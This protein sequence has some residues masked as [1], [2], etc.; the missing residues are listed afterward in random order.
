MDDLNRL[1]NR[2]I[3]FT[4]DIG[5]GVGNAPASVLEGVS[6][7]EKGLQMGGSATLSL[8]ETSKDFPQLSVK[9]GATKLG[10]A[11][12]TLMETSKDFSLSSVKTSLQGGGN[13]TLSLME[14][15]SYNGDCSERG[16]ASLYA[17]TDADLSKHPTTSTREPAITALVGSGILFPVSE[18]RYVDVK[19]VHRFIRVT[20]PSFTVIEVGDV[21]D[22]IMCLE[23]GV[24]TVFSS[25]ASADLRAALLSVSGQA[26]L[27][28]HLSIPV[29]VKGL[30]YMMSSLDNVRFDATLRFWAKLKEVERHIQKYLE[31]EAVGQVLMR[32]A[33]EWENSYYIGS[34]DV[35]FYT[36]VE[37]TH[38]PPPIF[39]VERDLNAVCDLETY[40][41]KSIRD[42]VEVSTYTDQI[43]NVWNYSRNF[44]REAFIVHP[45]G[46][47]FARDSIMYR[48]QRIMILLTTILSILFSEVLFAESAIAGER[49]EH[50]VAEDSLLEQVLEKIVFGA[51]G[52]VVASLVRVVI[53]FVFE[54]AMSAQHRVEQYDD[55]AKRSKT[56]PGD[57]SIDMPI[58]VI[59]HEVFLSRAKLRLGKSHYQVYTE[60]EHLHDREPLSEE[61]LLGILKYHV[62]KTERVYREAMK[63]QKVADAAHVAAQMQHSKARGLKYFWQRRTLQKQRAAEHY[64]KHLEFHLQ[65]HSTF[66]KERFLRSKATKEEMG[67]I[68]GTLYWLLLVHPSEKINPP[69]MTNGVHRPAVA[70]AQ[71]AGAWMVSALWNA[72]CFLYI[73]LWLFKT[74]S[75]T[76]WVLNSSTAFAMTWCFSSPVGIFVKA[77]VLPILT[78]LCCGMNRSEG[79]SPPPPKQGGGGQK[80]ESAMRTSELTSAFQDER[81]V[82]DNG[83][84]GAMSGRSSFLMK[85]AGLQH[86]TEFVFEDLEHFSLENSV[87]RPDVEAV[88]KRR[89][90]QQRAEVESRTREAQRIMMLT[91]PMTMTIIH[92]N[93]DHSD[94]RIED[95]ELQLSENGVP[96]TE[97]DYVDEQLTA[98]K[99]DGDDNGD[100]VSWYDSLRESFSGLF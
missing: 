32:Q 40:E 99:N 47:I 88:L 22:Q 52:A 61:L 65:R 59:R 95:V 97:E 37:A 49:D 35:Q 73:I 51:L 57:L 75:A 8:M 53:K 83:G 46:M 26:S 94:T 13:A 17:L 34:K 2:A 69:P 93:N 71:I 63:L 27:F 14:R 4:E 74:Q 82:L 92:D 87:S 79:G 48:H 78:V 62:T 41:I 70:T 24:C 58:E 11:A 1:K 84:G 42:N 36:V 3:S 50:N 54:S 44:M 7:V 15:M 20:N 5:E 12:T 81:G 68:K 67:F 85:A 100:D 16:A 76:S 89:H 29:L 38:V 33:S 77:I 90:E 45:V 55:E 31:H 30:L 72:W 96:G 6:S 80:G 98:A 43:E 21:L 18:E 25:T 23:T 10:N 28:G 91:E 19:E 39:E 60:E 9:K 66:A 64:L 86:D 56:S